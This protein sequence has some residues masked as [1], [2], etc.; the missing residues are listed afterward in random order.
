M[1]KGIDFFNSVDYLELKCPKCG[2][3]VDWGITTK[4][5]DDKEGQVC[6]DCGEKLE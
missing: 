1:A 6:N 3:K 2:N 4:W 5:C